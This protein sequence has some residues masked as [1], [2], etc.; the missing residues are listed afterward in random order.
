MFTSKGRA[1]NP[2]TVNCSITLTKGGKYLTGL[3]WALLAVGIG[4]YSA[5]GWNGSVEETESSSFV[6]MVWCADVARW[7]CC[8]ER[9]QCV[10]MT[11]VSDTNK[12]RQNIRECT[13]RRD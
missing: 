4:E 7:A 13:R 2:A 5:G 1:N 9:Q 8:G 12:V 10:A 3:V 6:L 11:P